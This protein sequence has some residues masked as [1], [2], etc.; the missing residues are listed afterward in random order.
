M[1]KKKI[2]FV[3]TFLFFFTLIASAQ[4]EETRDG[5]TKILDFLEKN[6]VWVAGVV[7]EVIVKAIPN[8]QSYSFLRILLTIF[9]VLVP[10]RKKGGGVHGHLSHKFVK[11]KTFSDWF[12]ELIPF[13]LATAASVFYYFWQHFSSGSFLESWWHIIP[14]ILFYGVAYFYKTRIKFVS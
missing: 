9:D 10:D 2:F 8:W 1:I 14:I 5:L 3:L 13:L 6:W 11:V 4:T 12:E 7:Y